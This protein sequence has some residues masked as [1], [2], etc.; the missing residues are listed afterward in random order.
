MGTEPRN[1]SDCTAEL[2]VWQAAK[3]LSDAIGGLIRRPPLQNDFALRDQLN[4]AALS[5]VA[6]IA[7]GFARGG[8]K[9]TVGRMLRVLGQKLGSRH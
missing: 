6:N 8:R 7:E 3:A 9:D 5:I 2:R 4:A 1:G